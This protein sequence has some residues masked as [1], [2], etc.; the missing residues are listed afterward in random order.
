MTRKKSL[1]ELQQLT[2]EFSKQT[3]SEY[4]VPPGLQNEVVLGSEL[5]GDSWVFELY[6]PGERPTDA[7]V[8]A[9]LRVDA[10]TGK[11]V[12]EEVNLPKKK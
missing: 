7:R 10:Y 4:Q 2:A 9:R 12:V 8:I 3:L 11:A 1:E 6:I 5:D